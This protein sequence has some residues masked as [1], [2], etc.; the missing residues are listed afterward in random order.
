[1]IC[2]SCNRPLSSQA[3]PK[4]EACGHPR[5]ARGTRGRTGNG[6]RGQGAESPARK[7][8]RRSRECADFGAGPFAAA[9]AD[10]FAVGLGRL[11]QWL[12]A[13][14]EDEPVAQP[15][16]SLHFAA[17]LLRCAFL[18]AVGLRGIAQSFSQPSGPR[19]GLRALG[20]LRAEV[21]CLLCGD[22]ANMPIK[23]LR[24]ARIHVQVV[25]VESC[26]PGSWRCMG[27]RGDT[28]LGAWG[29]RL[30]PRR[31]GGDR[32]APGCRYKQNRQPSRLNGRLTR[33]Q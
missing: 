3:N 13:P 20:A 5:S 2:K 4:R 15:G 16:R 28:D 11:Q 29:G 21:L 33:Q 31:G 24:P 1:M 12:N 26:N 19:A 9:P 10:R 17:K 22:Q 30:G 25:A 14:L 6:G 23:S 8:R 32:T 7:D 18:F 27:G